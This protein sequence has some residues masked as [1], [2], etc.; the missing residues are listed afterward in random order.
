M[1]I[2]VFGAGA[3]GGHL[4][5]RLSNAGHDVG[6]VVRSESAGIIA[7]QGLRLEGEGLAIDARVR[8]SDEP[9]EL[10]PQ[11]I[12]LVTVKATA[13]ATAATMLAPLVDAHTSVVFVQNGLPWWYGHGPAGVSAALHVPELQAMDAG[14]HLA[15]LLACGQ[16]LGAVVQSSNTLVAPG[17]IHNSSP[18][19][20]E[21]R[22]G[23]I[24]DAQSARVQQLR[25]LLEHAGLSSPPVPVL[26]KVVWGKLVMNLAGSPLCT[27]TRSDARLIAADAGLGAVFE[28]LAREALA[29]AAAHGFTFTPSEVDVAALRAGNGSAHR[30]SML[31]DFERGVALE[32]DAILRAPQRCARAAGV[33]T[34][35]LDTVIALLDRAVATR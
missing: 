16:V 2:A 24:D 10:G 15:H 9:R 32:I 27:L 20:N 8:A 33:A 11:D 5:A 30:P 31:Q 29:V 3:V 21:L 35:V 22:V 17:L 19:R 25:A 6:V 12:V 14:G 1:R 13:L 23:E 18:A 4:A 28:N 26:R 34:P 7:R